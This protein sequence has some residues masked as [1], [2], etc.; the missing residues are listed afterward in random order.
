M[1]QYVILSGAGAKKRGAWQ[2]HTRL[3]TNK[4]IFRVPQGSPPYRH[5]MSIPYYKSTSADSVKPERLTLS[6]H[7]TER[8]SLAAPHICPEQRTLGSFASLNRCGAHHEQPCDRLFLA[9]ETRT[10]KHNLDQARHAEFN[11]YRELTRDSRTEYPAT[12]PSVTSAVG[13]PV[14]SSIPISIANSVSTV[15]TVSIAKTASAAPQVLVAPQ[16]S[17]ANS[18]SYP[19]SASTAGCAT[20]VRSVSNLNS[21]LAASQASVAP[22]ASAANSASNPDSAAGSAMAVWS[23][24]ALASA[25]PQA[26][27]LASAVF[28]ASHLESASALCQVLHPA[29]AAFPASCLASALC[30]ALYPASVVFPAWSAVFPASYPASA[31]FPASYPAL[32]VFPASYLESA[33]QVCCLRDDCLVPKV[34]SDVERAV[35]VADSSADDSPNFRRIPDGLSNTRDAGDTTGSA[36]DTDSDPILPTRR[37]CNR[38]GAIPNSIPSRPIPTAGYQPAALQSQ[39][40]L[41]N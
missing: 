33:A 26:L 13:P 5:S 29:S 34:C 10:V 25:Q 24:P 16:A 17:A 36:D 28:P 19:S 11:P 9:E 40:L 14:S 41:R 32:A 30:P 15:K 7:R 37:D 27:H 38:R 3:F 2:T 31:V 20:A 39:S 4:S 6:H 1:A 21:A 18:A 22:Q 23:A 8:L 12:R 35:S